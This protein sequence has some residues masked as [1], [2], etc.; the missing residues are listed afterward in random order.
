VT[1]GALKLSLIYYPDDPI[2]E[3]LAIIRRAEELGFYACYLTDFPYRK[4]P[5]IVMAAAARETSRIRLG[6]RRRSPRS[7]SSAEGA[8]TR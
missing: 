5:W 7:T 2:D 3:A 1:S 4:D 8:P 6:P